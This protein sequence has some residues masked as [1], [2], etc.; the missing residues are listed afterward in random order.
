M[1]DIY[2]M[3]GVT[4]LAA[5]VAGELVA[6][7]WMLF[8]CVLSKAWPNLHTFFATFLTGI[9]LAVPVFIV[10]MFTTNNGASR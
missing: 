3:W 9:I 7:V 4:A 6:L 8:F 2:Q 1:K 10:L 5:F